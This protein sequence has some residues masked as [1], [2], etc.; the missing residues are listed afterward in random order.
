MVVVIILNNLMIK[1]LIWNLYLLLKVKGKKKKW[2]LCLVNRR[3]E[4][5]LPNLILVKILISH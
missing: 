3:K 1:I 5:N 2:H 4:I